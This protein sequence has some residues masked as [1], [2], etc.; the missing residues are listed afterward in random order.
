MNFIRFLQINQSKKFTKYNHEM[1]QLHK[2][3]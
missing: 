2:Y 1:Q 3:Q